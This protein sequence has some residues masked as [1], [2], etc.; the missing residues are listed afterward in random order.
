M[1]GLPHLNLRGVLLLDFSA[2]HSLSMTNTMFKHNKA[3]QCTWHKVTLSRRSMINFI[4]SI[5]SHVSWTLQKRE[6]QSCPVTVDNDLERL[7]GEEAQKTWQTST[8]CEGLMGTS[9][10][11]SSLWMLGD[12]LGD[13][14][15]EQC[16]VV[17]N[18]T[19]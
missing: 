3:H 4:V 12:C 17:L 13:M 18:G 5:S 15:L 14:S 19:F 8:Y 7:A 6:G 1:N 16:V 2:H 9:G 11:A 10:L